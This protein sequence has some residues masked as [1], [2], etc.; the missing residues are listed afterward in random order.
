M[1][2]AEHEVEEGA[3]GVSKERKTP[4]S[5]DKIFVKMDGCK[6]LP[7]DVSPNEKIG[8][9]LRRGERMRAVQDRTHSSGREEDARWRKRQEKE[10]VREERRTKGQSTESIRKKIRLR[11]SRR[12]QRNLWRRD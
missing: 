4:A 10:G 7:L 6:T 11:A 2:K 9:I 8:D 12:I 3:R 5:A 1:D